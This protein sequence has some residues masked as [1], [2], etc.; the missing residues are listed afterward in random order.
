[1]SIGLWL[2]LGLVFCG[3]IFLYTQTKDRWKWGKGG[4]IFLYLIGTP[5]AVWLIYLCGDYFYEEYQ[6]RPKVISEFKGIKL[7][8]S[9]Q[10]VIFKLGKPRFVIEPDQVATQLQEQEQKSVIARLSNEDQRA[11]A[12]GDMSA[13][14][15]YGLKVL[16]G[17][18]TMDK[19]P[20]KLNLAEGA[21]G[22]YFFNDVNVV[23]KTKNNVVNL[24][25]YICKNDSYDE[26]ELNG[27]KCG[28]NGDEILNKFGGAVRVLCNTSEDEVT[29]RVYDVVKYGTRYY[30]EKN[31]V[32]QMAIFPP[33]ELELAIGK[34]WGKC[35]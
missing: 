31:L 14:S 28:R 23:T 3:V 30:L 27:I 26:A 18:K 32:I 21:D 16:A 4:K 2:F 12:K 34:N 15:D 1:M 19:E 11:I 10:D 35:S 5:F 29:S 17:S 9:L 22:E 6:G 8:E 24:I 25:G 20:A 7:G 33:A 13:V